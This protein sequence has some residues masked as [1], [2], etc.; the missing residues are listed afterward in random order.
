MISAIEEASALCL[1]MLCLGVQ[2]GIDKKVTWQSLNLLWL[3]YDQCFAYRLASGT[4]GVVLS[5][6]L[7][8]LA[9]TKPCNGK[10]FICDIHEVKPLQWI[11]FVLWAV[12]IHGL[13]TALWWF[14]FIY[15]L[16]LMNWGKMDL[17]NLRLCACASG[18]CPRVYICSG[19]VHCVYCVYFEHQACRDTCSLRLHSPGFPQL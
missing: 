18:L 15:I 12:A 6:F 5:T 16:E 11:E 2:W 3:F 1:P 13:F 10:H 17:S 9:C 14:L 19:H 7:F 8:V 4:C